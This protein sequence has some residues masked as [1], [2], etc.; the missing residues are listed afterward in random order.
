MDG[1]VPFSVELLKGERVPPILVELPEIKPRHFREEITHIFEDEVE[2][3]HDEGS[4]GNHQSEHKLQY[5]YFL[6]L[7]DPGLD[8]LGVHHVYHK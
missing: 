5:G 1:F 8:E 2:A 4:A 3:E 7:F 6:P